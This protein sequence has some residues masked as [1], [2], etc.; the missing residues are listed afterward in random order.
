ML[1]FDQGC[2]E[3]AIRQANWD[4]SNVRDK[5]RGDVDEHASAVRSSQLAKLRTT[6]E[7]QVPI[8][9]KEPVKCLLREASQEDVWA[10]IRNLL[11]TLTAVSEFSNAVDE[12]DFDQAAVD[13]LVQEIRDYARSL[14]EVLAR[15]ESRDVVIFM[16]DR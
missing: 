2:E 7:E 10:S 8:E 1:E 5:L 3:A 14:V 4:A 16:K 13:T 6:Y 9:L 11:Q 12:F 15:E